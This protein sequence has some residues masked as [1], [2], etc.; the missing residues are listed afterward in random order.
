MSRKSRARPN[1]IHD[2][3]DASPAEAKQACNLSCASSRMPLLEVDISKHNGM[4][5]DVGVFTAILGQ[6]GEHPTL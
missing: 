3:T 2:Q 1:L 6:L 5:L 4:L